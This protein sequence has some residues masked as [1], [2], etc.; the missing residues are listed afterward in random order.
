MTAN[1]DS[2][3]RLRR[4]LA[5]GLWA[6]PVFGAL[7][8]VSNLTHQPYYG[9]DFAAYADY[10]TTPWFLTSHLVASIVGAG[11]GILGTVSLALLLAGRRD[12]PG[13]ALLGAALSTM[14]QVLNTAVFGVAAFAQPAIGRAYQS[15]LE[16]SVTL[17]SDVYGPELISTVAVAFLLWTAGAV[18][19]GRE[20]RATGPGLRAAGTTYAV[21]LPLFYLAGPTVGV[22]QPFFGAVFTAAAVVIARRLSAAGH[23]QPRVTAAGGA[24]RWTI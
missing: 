19:V 2:Q 8:T 20:I 16:D 6:L 10:V 13:R 18:V 11:L 15:G 22:L 24:G 5:R 1:N 21:S 12:R 4:H 17:N 3:D 7:L 9:D 23:S 14:A